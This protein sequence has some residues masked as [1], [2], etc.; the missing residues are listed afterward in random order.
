[1]VLLQHL[2]APMRR[3]RLSKALPALCSEVTVPSMK[4]MVVL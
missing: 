2:P 3:L 1:M 4:R